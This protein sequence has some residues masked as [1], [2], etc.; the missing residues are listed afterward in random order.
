M[1]AA[2]PG[3]VKTILLNH[4]KAEHLTSIVTPSTKKQGV[5]KCT[6]N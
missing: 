2:L 4:G 5:T 3:V 1:T 6:D